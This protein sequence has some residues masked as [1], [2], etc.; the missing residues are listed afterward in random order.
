MTTLPSPMFQAANDP[1]A[2]DAAPLGLYLHIPFCRQRCKFC[3]FRV[4]TDKNS[5]DIET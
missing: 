3:Y 2:P 4:Y 5:N 1:N